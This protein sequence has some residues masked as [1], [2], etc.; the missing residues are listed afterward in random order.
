MIFFGSGVL[1]SWYVTCRSKNGSH[2]FILFSWLNKKI[3]LSKKQWDISTYFW[4][5]RKCKDV[6]IKVTTYKEFL[7]SRKSKQWV[8]FVI[9]NVNST[10]QRSI[11]ETSRYILTQSICTHYFS[12][13]NLG[14][15]ADLKKTGRKIWGAKNGVQKAGSGLFLLFKER[16][17]SLA[18]SLLDWKLQAE[19]IWTRPWK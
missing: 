3:I 4:V 17:G 2:N 12:F 13:E 5:D 19:K 14:R 8:S 1:F 7:S 18:S 16:R 11:V 6:M 15:F 9:Q 10:D